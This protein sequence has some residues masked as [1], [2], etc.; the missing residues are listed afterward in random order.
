MSAS[1][2]LAR[3]SG[4]L[5]H[6]NTLDLRLEVRDVYYAQGI[7][8]N[9][10]AEHPDLNMPG[11]LINP[12]Q[13]YGRMQTKKPLE[14]V[15]H[16]DRHFEYANYEQ[17]V[18]YNVHRLVE[19]DKFVE[20]L[21]T[22]GAHVLY[23]GHARFGRGPC[24]GADS[25]PGEDWEDGHSPATGLFRM[26]YPYLAVPL[27]SILA[28]GYTANLVP[29]S[30]SLQESDCDPDLKPHLGRLKPM[31][32]EQMGM[33]LDRVKVKDPEQTWWA[34][35]GYFAQQRVP[36]AVLH[37]GWD[38]TTTSPWDLGATEM[39]AR[40]FIHFGCSTYKHNHKVVRE[41]KG[42][43]K[44]GDSG[45]CYFTS[46][47]SYGHVAVFYLHHLLSY[48]QPSRGRA[49]E[50]SLKYAVSKTNQDLASSGWGF[51]LK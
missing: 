39:K 20:A 19:R 42:W 34:Y 50:D 12:S 27:P 36:Y 38:E 1:I 48:D 22:D 2:H 46:D 10:S 9:N 31:T 43:K 51:R 41:F 40:V 28:H 11:V 23:T 29:S 47:L 44:E 49:W 45:H 16:S 13:G 25:S 24:F 33:P 14:I 26:G 7:E 15:E 3:T 37:A 5:K 8:R 35:M 17:G 30:V 18:L 21:Q 6:L 32:A 4:A